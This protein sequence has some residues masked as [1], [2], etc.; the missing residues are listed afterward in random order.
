MGIQVEFNP[1]LA[2]RKF[3]IE[4]REKEECFPENLEKGKIYDFLKKGQRNYYI[5]DNSIWDFGEIPLMITEGREKLS[6]PVASVKI[7]EATHFLKNG[8]VWTK[9]KFKIINVFDI[10]DSK[11]NFEA[12][13]R[14]KN[15]L[16]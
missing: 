6:R 2:L 3:G 9:G 1:D 4:G 13:R 10:N 7:I 16:D 12:C 14:I 15:D 8:E 11:I 5:S